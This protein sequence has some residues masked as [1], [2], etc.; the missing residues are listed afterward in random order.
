MLEL[1]AIPMTDFECMNAILPTLTDIVN[2]FLLT[3]EFPLIFKKAIVKPLLKT[4]SLDP[5]D[6]KN[7]RPISNLFLCQ[8]YLRKLCYLKYYNM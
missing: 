3:G 2:H 5:E 1:D 4:T 7:Y 6:L 8:K